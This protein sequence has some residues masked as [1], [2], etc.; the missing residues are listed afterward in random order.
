MLRIA[1][2]DDNSEFLE[3]AVDLIKRWSEQSSTP[4]EIY[5]FDNGDEL[6]AKNAVVRIDIIFLDIIMPLLNGMDT[7]KELRQTNTNV[8]IIFLTSSSEFALESYAVK[9]YDYLLKP[10]SYEKIK[11]VLDECSYAF[12]KE[13]KNIVFKTAYGYQKLF[14]YDI[15]YAEAQNKKVVIYLRSGKTV[16]AAEPFY[17]F[18]KR[19]TDCD[20]FFKCHRSYL[21]YIQNVDHFNMTEIITKSGH[22][23]PIARGYGKAF[24]EAYF[25]WMFGD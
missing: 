11:N 12:D 4:L 10:I 8:K 21:V 15:E 24:Q 22:R 13:P 23:V 2:C 5:R 3:Q 1:V 18:V 19:L 17:F 16:D 14:Y 25:S 7:A 9:A 20:G 6:I